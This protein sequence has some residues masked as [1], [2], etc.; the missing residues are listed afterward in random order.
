MP[1]EFIARNGITSLGNVIVS[2]SL[3]TTGA[4]TISGS[5][6]SSSF[7]ATASSADNFLVRSTLTAQTLV[8]QT[9]TSSISTITGST[10]F[11]STGSNTHSFTGSVSMTGSLAV[12]T[13]GTEF[14]VTNT[15][16]N[17]GNALTDSHTI[18]G[19]L[20]VN[21]NGLFVSGSGLVGIG[22]TS[23][24]YKLD[25]NADS[26]RFG[27]G[28]SATLHMNVPNSSG[29]SGNINVG[30]SPRIT[31]Q[32]TGN[33]G[34]GTTS[35][36]SLL[37]VNGE[38][39]IIYSKAVASNPLDVSSFSGL[40]TVN[41]NNINGSL[42]GIAM[43]ANSDY[44]AAA[45]I[46]A[47]R[48]SGTSAD[49]VF[50]AGSATAGERMR[51]TSG[52]NVGIGTTSPTNLLHTAGASA[53]PSLRLGSTSA[54]YHWD[55]GRENATTGDFVFNNAN[56]GSS[57]EKVR[58][59]VGGNVGIGTTSPSQKLHI[60]QDNSNDVRLQLQQGTNDYACAINLVGNND[61]GSSYNAILSRTGTNTAMWQIG[62]GGV[63][64]TM[65]MY[66]AGSERM[67]ITSSGVKFQNG[68]SSLNYYEEGSWTPAL[69]NATVSYSDRSGSYVR[70]GNYVFVRWGFRISS[71]S[72]QSD[73]ITIAGLP[74]TSV[75]WG[76]YQEPNI[77]VN[78]G[79]LA[80]ADNAY[81]ARVFVGGGASS[82]FGR[83]ANNSDT[84]W[85]T[86]D[87][88]NGSWIIGEIFY[89][90]S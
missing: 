61:T 36:V 66:T 30:G 67:R 19:S 35:P 6:A 43:Y 12:V 56:G 34:I 74:F 50:Y 25:V 14:Q 90:V 39:R 48:T 89:N 37:Q 8:V 53:T 69:Q 88:Q 73:T 15:G 40:I 38:S 65:I 59:T 2:G 82:L 18:S 63:A 60:Y 49:M 58:I 72:G 55:I 7:A 77:S 85:N 5:I 51:I 26:I 10:N 80:T 9:I 70:I 45:G 22:T 64:N 44:N 71:I 81:K 20:R 76:A 17:L 46:F 86:N 52:G 79:A 75:S 87:L 13:N 47:S 11:G 23:P 42:S 1:N 33:V 57:T 54:G 62:G 31:I 32:G 24:S 29:V 41:T 68:S 78:T 83:I 28:G 21:P 4:I 27:D 3:T 16:V 84:P